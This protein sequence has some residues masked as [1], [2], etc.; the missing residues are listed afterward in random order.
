MKRLIVLFCL[1][2]LVSCSSDKADLDEP[3]LQTRPFYMGFTAFPYDLS[4]EASVETF[5]SVIREGDLFLNHF[6]HGVPW[7][8]A[9]NDL[10]FPDDVQAT[11]D[12]TKSGLEPNTKILLTATPTNQ[13]RD[14][15]AEY[16]NN[17][18][19]HQPLPDSWKNKT[20]DDS[21]VIA[22]YINY[23]KRII[24]E[25]QPDYFAYGI[26]VTAAFRKDDVAFEEFLVLVE[27]VYASLKS[28]YPALP[29]F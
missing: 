6:D 7:N 8:E 16:W 23:C 1:L 9:L 5:Q 20:F 10:P 12:V 29:I 15:L 14:G 27:R 19:S 17:A 24:D 11:I 3:N 26:E 13:L 22:A 21:D 25:I 4:I 2:N 18:G 28:E